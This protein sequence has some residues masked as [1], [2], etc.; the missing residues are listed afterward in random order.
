[1]SE[2]QIVV[3]ANERQYRRAKQQ[4]KAD[5][6]TTVS[7]GRKLSELLSRTFYR[8]IICEGVDLSHNIQGEGPL[9]ELLK[10]RQRTYA[11]PIWIEL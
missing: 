7:N 8:I 11:N 6:Y 4:A 5:P 9:G 3:C 2:N 1:M 10:S